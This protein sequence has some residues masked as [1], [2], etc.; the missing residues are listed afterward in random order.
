M[1]AH[2]SKFHRFDPGDMICTGSPPGVGVAR[3]PQVFLRP[4]DTV[5]VEIEGVGTLTNP[6]IGYE[7]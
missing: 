5:S 1:I 3:N 4:G 7:A 6:V 2:Y